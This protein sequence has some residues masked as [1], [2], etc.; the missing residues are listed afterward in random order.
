MAYS[1]PLSLADFFDMLMI[2]QLELGPTDATVTSRTRGG[3]VLTAQV[4]NVVWQGIA[5]IVM[6]SHGDADALRAMLQL[7]RRP[8]GSFLATPM[9]RKGPILDPDGT[10]LGAAAPEIDQIDAN[11]RDVRIKDLPAAYALSAGDYLSYTYGS[12]PTRY[13]FHQ[14]AQGATANGSGVASGL[15]VTPPIPAGASATL[16]ITLV[17]PVFKAVLADA[18]GYGAF[19]PAKV[20]GMQ[21]SFVQTLR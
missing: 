9:Q 10:I 17:K 2:G 4:G 1:F 8:G 5:Q 11:R 21:F 18:P 7:L 14:L 20:D 13:G 19:L 6:H 3:E 12:S 15:E 16:A